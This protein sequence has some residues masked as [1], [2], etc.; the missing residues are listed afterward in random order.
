MRFLPLA[1]LVTVVACRTPPPPV[2]KP[3]PP[4]DVVAPQLRL[5]EGVAPLSYALN[6]TVVAGEQTFGGDVTIELD[7]TANLDV[8]WL[9]STGLTYSEAEFIGGGKTTRARTEVHGS[10]FVAVIPPE[11]LPAGKYS[12]RL[13]YSSLLSR[14]E[15][16]GVFQLD[17]DGSS[18]VV[19]Q[20][21]PIGARRA[22]PC[23]DEP[24][25]KVPWKI[26]LA[27][28][29]TDQA[30]SN[31]PMDT[32]SKLGAGIK[33]VTFKP[34]A[35]LPT[36][37][38]AL[39]AGPFEVVDAG[40]AGSKKTPLRIITP[41]GRSAQ[42]KF[43]AAQ[44]GKIL[45]A[46][47]AYFGTP[48][49]Y[50]KL[51]EL[52]FPTVFS[53]MEHPGLVTFGHQTLLSR[54]EED[55]SQRQRDCVVT[56]AHEQSHMWFGDWVT[57]KWWDDIWLNESFAQWIDWKIAGGLHPEW[58]LAVEQAHELGG[59]LEADSLATARKMRQPIAR[60]DD[61]LNVFD[62]ITYSKGASVLS[63][64]EHWLGPDVFQAGV[65]AHLGAHPFGNASAD[66]FLAALSKAAG[67]D[68][69]APL[70]TFLDQGGAPK[71]TVTVECSAGQTAT[72]KLA[73]TRNLPLGSKGDAAL[74]WQ[75]PVCLRWAGK[76]DG[77]LCT[78]LAGDEATVEL[79]GTKGC[80]AWV[81]PN[82]GFHGYYQSV[83][84]M[85]KGKG[86][87]A[88]LEAKTVSRAEKVGLLESLGAL[89]AAGQLDVSDALGVVPAA[90]KQ[91][92]PE[93]WAQAA[94][95]AE[96]IDAALVTDAQRPKY[97][98]WL[99][100]GFGVRAKKLGMKVGAGDD[101]ATRVVRPALIRLLGL[102]GQ[103]VALRTEAQ[104][105]ALAWLG[106][107]A[108][109]HADLV[110]AVLALA[111]D[112]PDLTVHDR[113][114]AAVKEEKDQPTRAR[115]LRGLSSVR[116]PAR[117]GGHFELVRPSMIDLKESA[118]LL[119]GAANDPRTRDAAWQFL[120]SNVDTLTRRLPSE[121]VRYL[122]YLGAG[123]CDDAGRKKVEGFF[124]PRAGKIVGMPHNLDQ[125]LEGIDLCIAKNARQEAS[126][127]K[128]LK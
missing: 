112:G 15:A 59:A 116:D 46:L 87:I 62:Q 71:V 13:V 48:Y 45:E 1:L 50:D 47:E 73:Q 5:P 33:L 118:T 99:Q 39:A 12:V 27:V 107:H 94:R 17:D 25:F 110:D 76:P 51:D 3:A 18:Y 31:A 23:F 100:Q 91:D 108:A 75:V 35:P 69:A 11:P 38:V 105:Q 7:A 123:Y 16:T 101:D 28:R 98:A 106:N 83:L 20:F 63:N 6:L 109:V 120:E 82:D 43:A 104:K 77:H 92:V 111:A 124:A 10:D 32:E 102:T 49:P 24:Q 67:K 126:V 41:K 79:A 66:E 29:N 70:K 89:A 68:V 56:T 90:M 127:A 42:A 60:N 22:F 103:D 40:T 37:L 121:E 36:Y 55:T 93:V 52:A 122:V 119:Y 61:I 78:L 85:P 54:P 95:L 115:L 34:T 84:V 80:P 72:A 125:V 26:S 81:L 9:N 117:L 97:Q 96:S 88:V 4:R 57:M 86:A 53:A 8:L 64:F 2:A 44:S 114:L 19:S 74:R 21:E 65:R 14:T 128:L 30:F 58:N 113:L